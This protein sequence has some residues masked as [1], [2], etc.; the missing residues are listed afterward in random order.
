MF[1]SERCALC[2]ASWVAYGEVGSVPPEV[3]GRRP[4]ICRRRIQRP[5]DAVGDRGGAIAAAELAS[6]EAGGKG[7]VDGALDGTGGLGGA[8]VAVTIGEPVQHHRGGED[9]R[10]RIGEPL[11]H[12]IGRGAVTRLKYRVLVADVGRGRHAH[13]AD[14][15]GSE[16]GE[17]VA[18]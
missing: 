16:I 12:D 11:A 8:L 9:H 18:P 10:G 1:R 13:A 4:S 15:A 7:A 3:H 5:Q 17:D 6:L 14:Q 2:T